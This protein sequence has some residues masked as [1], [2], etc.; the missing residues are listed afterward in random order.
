MA[1]IMA[2]IGWSIGGSGNLY[3]TKNPTT[4]PIINCP[5][6]P[7][8]KSPVW[9]AKQTPRPVK[10]I[11]VELTIAHPRFLGVLKIPWNKAW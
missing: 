1:K 9:K 2:T 10:I 7:I 4:V 3:P 5:S 6:A 8:L 11:G